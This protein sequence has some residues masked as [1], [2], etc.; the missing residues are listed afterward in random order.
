MQID[1]DPDFEGDHVVI[2][3]IVYLDKT[4]LDGMGRYSAYPL[5]ISIGNFSWEYYNEKEGMELCAL[6]PIVSADSNWEGPGYKNGTDGF[7]DTKRRVQHDS[8]SIIFESGRKASYTGFDFIDPHG[9]PRKGVPQLFI[10]AKDLGEASAISGVKTNLCDSCHVPPKELNQL[11]KALGGDYAPREEER[12]KLALRDMFDLRDSKAP[13]RRV[14]EL[15][16]VNGLHVIY[17][18]ELLSSSFLLPYHTIE[19][20]TLGSPPGLL[21]GTCCLQYCHRTLLTPS[22]FQRGPSHILQC[23]AQGWSSWH[24]PN[25]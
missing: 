19:R 1:A 17:V 18:S 9:T 4:T 16:W 23:L 5:Y 21:L 6:L 13:E 12:M 20:A 22:V 25:T 3:I 24:G 11:R 15:Q 8:M 7:R 10:I 2:P 14:E